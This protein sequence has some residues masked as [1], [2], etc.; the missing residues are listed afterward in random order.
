M[1]VPV[2]GSCGGGGFVLP[3]QPSQPISSLTLKHPIA[4]VPQISTVR[5]VQS[6]RAAQAAQAFVEEACSEEASPNADPGSVNIL[7]RDYFWNMWD[8][9]RMRSKCVHQWL[10]GQKN[11]KNER[12]KSTKTFHYHHLVPSS[13]GW[14]RGKR[15]WKM[16]RDRLWKCTCWWKKP[17]RTEVSAASKHLAQAGTCCTV[18]TSQGWITWFLSLLRCWEN[19]AKAHSQGCSGSPMRAWR[20]WLRMIKMIRLCLTCLMP[21]VFSHTQSF[22]VWSLPPLALQHPTP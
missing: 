11:K 13:G 2:L 5:S 15:H 16:L 19:T 20:R 22:Q 21:S 4:T 6:A 7:C 8:R 17:T 9:T 3:N 18:P 10:A 1:G 14:L 12:P